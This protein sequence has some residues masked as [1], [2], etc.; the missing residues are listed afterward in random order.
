MTPTTDEPDTQVMIV[1]DHEVVRWGL[2]SYLSAQPDIT[3]LD[4]AVD[5]ESTLARLTILEQAGTLPDVLLL[6]VMLPGVDGLQLLAQIRAR[7]PTVAVVMVTSRDESQH[8]QAALE[9][10]ASGYVVKGSPVEQIVAAIRTAHAGR[11]HLDPSAADAV[12]RTM[13]R[14]PADQDHLTAREREVLA[15]VAEGKSNREIGRAL[16]ISERTAQTHN[17]KILG[18]LGVRSRTQAA[19]RAAGR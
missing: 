19:L 10:G 8:V 9:G 14:Q 4:E 11:T 6:D 13:R 15:L 17:T 7:F 5:A 3:V 12:A 1:D 18:K 2:R 16:G